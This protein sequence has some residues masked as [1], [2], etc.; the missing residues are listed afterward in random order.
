MSLEIIRMENRFMRLP[1][2]CLKLALSLSMALNGSLRIFA[3]EAETGQE[4][5]T[6]KVMIEEDHSD[7]SEYT[8]EETVS[9]TENKEY[10]VS[11]P[12]IE[13]EDGEGSAE[14]IHE[15]EEVFETIEEQ[16]E[17]NISEE[18]E[19][20][21]KDT[22]ETEPAEEEPV[23]VPE[24]TELPED[25][26]EN[27]S[28]NEIE[29]TA[30]LGTLLSSESDFKY[31]V[32]GSTVTITKYVGT[33][34]VV[35]IP[36]TIEGN[37]VTVIGNNAFENCRNITSITLPSTI[38]TLGVHVFSGTT[39][40]SITI[41]KSLTTSQ[42]SSFGGGGPFYNSSVTEVIFESGMT[43]IPGNVMKGAS[44]L[45]TVS[46][47]DSVTK[48]NEK[49]FLDCV[50]LR[51]PVLPE[52]L[53][54]IGNSAFENC[55][56]ITGITLPS[57]IRTLGEHV[58]CGTTFTSI[59]I[60]K[61][62]TTSQASSFGGGGPFYNSS[63]KEAVFESGMT[64]IPGNVM[65]GASKLE[66]VSI[67]ESVTEIG[68]KAF[69]SCT[70][71]RS[72]LIPSGVKSISGD[73]FSGTRDLTLY[74]NYD[75]YGVIYAIDKQIT[76]ASSED[77]PVLKTVIDR[78]N[79]D[80]YMNLNSAGVNGKIPCTVQYS[81]RDDIRGKL[82][83]RRIVVYIPQG[84]E[85]AAGSVQ[86]NKEQLTDYSFNESTRK[87]V[88]NVSQDE[89]VLY[90]YLELT[91]TNR[92]L[93]YAYLEGKINGTWNLDVIGA[94]DETF[95]GLSIHANEFANTADVEVKGIGP[96]SG[97]IDLYVD[98]VL[99]KST[100]A[101]KSGC[102]SSTV[103]LSSLKENKQYIIKAVS[104]LDG[105][106][107]SAQTKVMYS[108]QAPVVTSFELI[109]A[110]H[111][112]MKLADLLDDEELKKPV[113]FLPGRQMD[114]E[115][116]FNSNVTI[117]RVYITSTRGGDVKKLEAVYDSSTN[118]YKTDGFFD[119]KN[120]YYVPGKIG[121]E[122]TTY[123]SDLIPT[124]E[125]VNHY[126]SEITQILNAYS[127][128]VNYS[129][130]EENKLTATLTVKDYLEHNLDLIVETQDYAD[131]ENI[132]EYYGITKDLADIMELVGRDEDGNY[133]WTGFTT[134]DSG[135]QMYI[136][137]KTTEPVIDIV[138][139]VVTMT[140]DNM[141]INASSYDLWYTASEKMGMV[142]PVVE[143]MYKYTKIQKETRDLINDI[144]QSGD[145]TLDQK[146]QAR[147]A[148]L[149][150]ESDRMH[151]L[152]ITMTMGMLV[153]GTVFPAAGVAFAAMMLMLNFSA[154][155]IFAMRSNR[156]KA[157]EFNIKLVMDPSGYVYDEATVE[158]LEGVTTTA[159]WIEY[160]PE[161]DWDEF[162]A[163]KPA[164]EEYGTVWNA[165]EYNQVNPLMTDYEG[166]YQW[167]VPEGW[168]RVKYEKEGYLTTWSE[169]LPVP[170]PQL[171]VNIGM[172][173]EN[174]QVIP[175]KEV[176]LD[177]KEATLNKGDSLQLT[178]EIIPEGAENRKVHWSSSA[179]EI[180]SVDDRGQVKAL[181]PG[182]AYIK[183][184]SDENSAIEDI[185]KIRVQFTD[186]TDPT[187]FYYEYIYD[188]VDKGITTG[189]PDGTFRPTA[190]CNRAAVVT[191]LWRLKGKPDPTKMATFKD[192]TGSSD[193]DKAISW[194]AESGITTGWDDNTFRP[195]NTCNR[196]AVLTFLWRA[197]GEPEPTQT[198][199]F[200]DMT[201]NSDFDKA[202]SW[203]VE[204]GITTGWADN[205][206]RPWNTCNRLA[207]VS[208]LGR[209]DA[210]NK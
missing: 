61:S 179:P 33:E 36:E 205:T 54:T 79:T 148:A 125:D 188:M 172:Q 156:I 62:L 158:R 122:Y 195:W 168:W 126:L 103:T 42:A 78:N 181:A 45:E 140:V 40:T 20:A 27:V 2:F 130:K 93:T 146:E 110:E 49:A 173:S 152:V 149:N 4:E 50:S 203:G 141:D 167:D 163:A 127:D 199:S 13:S 164:E 43:T 66:T 189:Y 128:R 76:F 60:P 105:E 18:S 28:E 200:K 10:E 114:F 53:E 194:A 209:Y 145:L 3:E 99:N 38:R 201:G 142:A 186:V 123:P 95:K 144:N 17:D 134:K 22:E 135:E 197:A 210:L 59:T 176:S 137:F 170:P 132:K 29:E 129:E 207:V 187:Q 202:I 14:E 183:A 98:G 153:A 169:W 81:I 32:S 55:R 31:T 155:Q 6:E 7:Y 63:V 165:N 115:V 96:S 15:P 106:E 184:V 82:S 121:I 46:I 80:Y 89:G 136:I 206:F 166:R 39:F 85:I 177:I 150:L 193:F 69:D 23:S 72:V 208:F 34:A 41:P 25:A 90:F 19:T 178:A 119:P 192:M 1:K 24:E 70:S 12:V 117:D 11:E 171:E 100:T 8:E 154:D 190:N 67:P 113:Y 30:E 44:K 101:D 64:T 74:C 118:T 161:T 124:R 111:E 91:G 9:E 151:F 157:G 71:L 191:F 26:E 160:D 83:G 87:A 131:V 133:L 48:I 159:Y 73:A 35:V 52:G 175:V 94:Y 196:A 185:C 57:T 47:P 116:G 108:A 182:V 120:H 97:R 112:E 5:N 68:S 104:A 143:C 37:P 180:V 198:A 77:I 65:K 21:E 56:N 109:Y 16:A 88:F 162:L 84:T 138:D 102:W 75:S 86:L 174:P 51:N 58:F 147:K 204:N 107:I 92:V 139:T